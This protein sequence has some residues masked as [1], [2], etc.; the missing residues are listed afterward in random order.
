MLCSLSMLGGLAVQAA[1]EE[2]KDQ[3]SPLVIDF[4]DA[5]YLPSAQGIVVTGL[6]GLVGTLKVNGDSA[7]LTKMADT[8]LQD[9]T[10][11]EKLSDSEVLL[12]TST[13]KIFLYDGTKLTELASLSEYNE[14]VLDIV[15]TNG[16]A[17]AVGARGLVARSDDGKKWENVEIKDIEQP[18]IAFPNA[19]Q[20]EWYFGVSNLNPDSVKL[21]AT[22]GGN[23][24]VAEQDYQLFPDEGFIQINKAFDADPAPS[25][26]F[27]FNPGPAFR[28]GDVSWNVVLADGGNVTL[29][30]EF[31][32]VI[33]S[34]DNG[35]TWVRR[36][37]VLSPKEPEP[38]YWL[39][40]AEHGQEIWLAGAAG[41]TRNSK[42]GGVTWTTPPTAGNEGLF[43][44]TI[45]PTGQPAI[46]GAVGLI[47]VLN[48]DKWQL[49]DRTELK[50]LS[51]LKTPVVMPDG[52]LVM[53]G[54]R[55]TTIMYKDGAWKRIPVTVQ[56]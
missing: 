39:A 19:S 56:E 32:M 14:P 15:V 34:T 45:L 42:D 44:I 28:V 54:G 53:L 26:S 47:G 52:T 50:L 51:W 9:F 24:P 5:A 55:S 36:D 7:V 3:R 23:A 1:D 12:G 16:Q 22:V 48:D 40:G 46:A 37:A 31:G 33:Q 30:G 11:L 27:A 43:G 38:A 18:V 2:V 6:H 21:N 13:G 29:A 41:V 10:A 8:P 20:G 25:I 4:I 35:K 49:A 17:W